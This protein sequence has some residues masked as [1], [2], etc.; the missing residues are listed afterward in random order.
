MPF[1]RNRHNVYIEESN[2]YCYWARNGPYQPVTFSKL[3]GWYGS[4]PAR[5]SQCGIQP[6][7][8]GGGRGD[9]VKKDERRLTSQYQPVQA[10]KCKQ[11][12]STRT[13]WIWPV[14]TMMWVEGKDI[15]IEKDQ[16]YWGGAGP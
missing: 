1:K 8:G 6:Q 5:I 16:Y 15:K 9:L 10:R 14:Q 2:L 13:G 3:T 7:G 4:L 12:T 11:H